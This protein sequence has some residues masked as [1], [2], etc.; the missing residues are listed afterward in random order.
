MHV[1]ETYVWKN[2]YQIRTVA[3]NALQEGTASPLV[4]ICRLTHTH[5]RPDALG[6]WGSV[7]SWSDSDLEMN[8][9]FSASSSSTSG[10]AGRSLRCIR[11]WEKVWPNEC[12]HWLLVWCFCGCSQPGVKCMRTYET[13][14]LTGSCCGG[15]EWARLSGCNRDAGR[16]KTSGR[17]CGWYFWGFCEFLGLKWK[18]ELIGP[19]GRIVYLLTVGSGDWAQ[20]Q[21]WAFYFTKNKKFTSCDDVNNLIGPN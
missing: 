16:F 18:I 19:N 6:V 1:R 7:C 2:I 8:Q 17:A 21:Y 9:R 14:V 12:V 11:W 15:A 5:T 4:H 3:K 20:D 10:S 13:E